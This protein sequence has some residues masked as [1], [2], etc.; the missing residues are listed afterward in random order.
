V[1]GVRVLEIFTHGA[2]ESSPLVIALHGRGGSPENLARVFADYPGTLQIALPQAPIP[3][4]SGSEWFDA[5]I[6]GADDRLTHALD[7]AEQQ[8]WPVLGTIAGGRR[9]IVTGFSQGGFMTYVLASRHPDAIVSAFPVSG[10]APRGLFPHDH[11]KSA[12]LYALHGT[13]DPV[14]PIQDDRATIAAF[15]TE[16]AIADLHE[17]PNTRHEMPPPLRADLLAHVRAA[18]ESVR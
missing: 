17:F 4:G 5:P 15:K 10:A 11:A 13:D 2:T 16:G 7:A 3:I 14:V 18:A 8:L 12:P 9:M 1:S 6:E